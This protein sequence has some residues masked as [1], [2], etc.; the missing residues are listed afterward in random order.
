MKR[1]G[2]ENK[3]E[4]DKITNQ[5]ETYKNKNDERINIK[6]SEGCEGEKKSK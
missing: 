3:L 2:N 6:V 5:D 4:K 1:I